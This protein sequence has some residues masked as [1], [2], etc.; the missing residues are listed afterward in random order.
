[1]R[2]LATNPLSQTEAVHRSR[3][4]HV[5]THHINALVATQDFYGFVG[6]PRLDHSITA[7]AQVV[8][9]CH[10]NQHLVLYKQDAVCSEIYLIRGCVHNNLIP[11]PA[12]QTISNQ[13]TKRWFPARWDNHAWSCDNG[14]IGHLARF[15]RKI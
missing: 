9:N 15:W 3:H 14:V 2:P 11:P 4:L 6:V 5:A 1:A 10:P 12:V 8:S 13:P 7:I